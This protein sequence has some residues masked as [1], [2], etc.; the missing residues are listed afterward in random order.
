MQAHSLYLHIPFCH[1]RC[2][3]CD[4]NTYSGMEALIPEYVGAL[5]QEIRF[6]ARSCPQRIPVHTIFFGGGTPSILPRKEISRIFDA[7][8]DEFTLLDGL[9]ISLEANP[10]KLSYDYLKFLRDL[11]I[12][13]ISLGMQSANPED[14]LLL[15]RQHEFEHVV[16]GV[17][18]I[19]KVGFENLNLDLIFGIPYQNLVSWQRTLELGISLNPDHFSLYALTI[20]TGTPLGG[21]VTKGLLS[22]PDPD[23]SAEM[24]EWAAEKLDING[25]EQYEISNWA[26]RN[27]AG[28]L[29]TCQHNLQYWRNLPYLGLGAGA[30][31]YSGGMRTATVLNPQ[32]YILKMSFPNN[33]SHLSPLVFPQTPV[34]ENSIAINRDDEMK[35]TM[36][37]G[38]RLTVEGVSKRAFKARF[39]VDLEDR[40]KG[41]IEQ[42]LNTGLLE[43]ESQT[44][45]K[46]RLTPQGR[47]LGNQV[48]MHFV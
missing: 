33:A 4:F 10:G 14:L 17:S 39:G 2:S 9:E 11:G 45:D 37:M 26:R 42:I 35:E 13:R 34:T 20:E 28:K 24:Y 18:L 3:Y 38:L 47:L 43:W 36:L 12:N 7:L 15:E 8:Q 23:L 32:E 6:I 31:G 19:R 1:H 27:P 5:C 46:L 16:R 21:W 29:L 25:F 48:F 44:G 22:E 40:F 41:E 30:H